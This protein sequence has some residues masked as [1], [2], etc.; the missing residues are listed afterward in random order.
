MKTGAEIAIAK[1]C[2]QSLKVGKFDYSDN[3]PGFSY[4]SIKRKS[5]DYYRNANK[6][7]QKKSNS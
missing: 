7:R 2:K 4:N 3:E 6:K 5:G 1:P